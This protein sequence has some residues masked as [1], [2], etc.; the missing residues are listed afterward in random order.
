M[1]NQKQF[2]LLVI[3]MVFTQI[4]WAGRPI[5][6]D[7]AGTA[8]P[9]TC[10][11]EG[12]Q[13]RMRSERA[14]VVAPACGVAPGLELGFD[15]TRGS[16]D[17]ARAAGVALKWLPQGAAGHSWA[18]TTALG[19]INAGLK[20]G[21]AYERQSGES[22]R[23]RDANLLLLLSTKFN[24]TLTLHT[25]LGAIRSQAKKISAG[26]LNIALVATPTERV[27]LFAESQ[28]NNRGAVFGP[29]VNTLGGRW[30][31]VKERFGLDATASRAV[32]DQSGTTY[33]IGFGWY[34]L[35]L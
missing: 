33:T 21:L 27:L 8:D 23:Y 10:Q 12:W 18:G 19:E 17:A 35:A 2:W 32:G 3:S 26:L 9:G 31:V 29:T 4:S 25:N 5:G 16:V 11:V 6:T 28:T 20:L 15:Y 1:T 7:D 13:E 30:W 14:L 34:G 24:D 22:W